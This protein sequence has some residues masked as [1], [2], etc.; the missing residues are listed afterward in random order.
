M[1][2]DDLCQRLEDQKTLVGTLDWKLVNSSRRIGTAVQIERVIAQG[3]SFCI[4]CYPELPDEQVSIVLMAEIGFKPRP[5]ARI[6]WRGNGHENRR[7]E[8]G[9]LQYSDAGRTH[10]HDPRLHRHLT[11]EQLFSGRLDLPVATKIDPEPASFQGLTAVASEILRIQNLN[12]IPV[13]P[14]S[15]RALPF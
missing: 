12:D 7:S 2:I 9:A 11:M 4:V 3:L 15:P 13:P 8:C 6:D 5:F 1:T 14:W 10:F